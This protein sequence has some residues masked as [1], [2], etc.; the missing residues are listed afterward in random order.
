MRYL[1]VMKNTINAAF[2]CLA[3]GIFTSVTI[4]GAYQILFAVPLIYF[5]YLAIKNKDYQ[6]PKSAWWLLAFTA[7][8]FISTVINLDH[9]PRPS[10]NFGKLKYALI[11]ITSI[12]ALRLWLIEATD[13]TK[14]TL[15]N[16]FFFSIILAAFAAVYDFIYDDDERATS[17][18]HSMRYGYGSAMI[19]VTTLSALLHWKKLESWFDRRWGIAAFIL[20]FVGMYLTYTRGALLG[21]LCAL[22]FVFYYYKPRLAYI[23]GGLAILVALSLGGFYLFGTG[24]YNSRF[25]VN[26]NVNSDVIRRSQWQAAVIATQEKPLLGWGFSNFHSQVDRIKIENNLAAQHFKDSHSHNLY[27]EIASGTGLIGLF[28]FL[29]W[30]INWGREILKDKTLTRS[31]VVPYGVVYTITGLFEVT[32]DTNNATML[33]F[34]YAL[35]SVTRVSETRDS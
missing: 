1:F 25:L 17:F 27:L 5:T 24:K 28:F 22:P 34:V 21:F 8:A 26:K 7:V 14:K 16:I 15:L 12:Y 32:L 19:L 20:G 33:F 13:K 10:K 11:G 29:G 4:L 9:I 2:F 30:L 6:L 31:L 23:V 18:L 35:S 3:A